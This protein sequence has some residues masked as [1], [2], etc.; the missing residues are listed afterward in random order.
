MTNLPDRPLKSDPNLVET[1]EKL[2]KSN[3]MRGEIR[4]LRQLL[5][6]DR[7]L[8]YGLDLD[9][10]SITRLLEKL[11]LEGS[12]GFGDQVLVEGKYHVSVREDRGKIPCPW[13][14]RF[15]SP[16]ATVF[17]ENMRNGRKIKYSVLGLHMIR[18][19]GFFQ[20]V[21]SP[22]RIDP[23]DLKDFLDA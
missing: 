19:H 18:R 5:D 7:A 3:F 2:R 16:K 12:K 22:F 17:A 4:T 13:G 1:E 9:L 6:D 14:D 15:F 23:A 8:V 20:G 10:D 21:G 11:Y